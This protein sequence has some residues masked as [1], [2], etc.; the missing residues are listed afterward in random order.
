MLFESQDFERFIG[1]IN[2]FRRGELSATHQEEAPGAQLSREDALIEAMNELD[3]LVGLGP[4]K[5]AVKDFTNFMK[6]TKQR[7]ENGIAT[8]EI[9]THFVF[10][11]SPGTGKTTIARLLTKLY[12]ALGILERGQI[13]ETDRHGLVAG[14]VGQTA[15]KTA[16]KIDEAE[17]GVL[18][19][20]EAYA[21]VSFGISG[22]GDYGS[23][24][25]QTLLKRMED[26]RGRFFVF[27]AGYPDNMETFI[28]SNPGLASRFDKTF[29]FEDYSAQEL[30]EIGLRLFADENYHLSPKAQEHIKNYMQYTHRFRDIYF[31]N[32][33]MVR[34]VVHEILKQHHLRV[35]N[36]PFS[37]RK[38][39]AN[40]LITFDDVKFLELNQSNEL[41]NRK[42]IGFKNN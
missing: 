33:R 19:I 32:A 12:K 22:S 4:V 1:I 27:A 20:D 25:I 36:M 38:A 23:E 37:E 42:R 11:G 26:D 39:N 14:F 10:T 35:S 24:A 30:Y 3:G 18:F 9:S 7:Q 21:L 6:V 16:E 15:L 28:K 17:G 8:D 41:F 5:N 40:V 29:R 2:K 13:V 34:S 31:G